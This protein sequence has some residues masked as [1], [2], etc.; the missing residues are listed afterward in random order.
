[1]RR[2]A[3]EAAARQHLTDELGSPTTPDER[4]RFDQEVSRLVAEWTKGWEG[5]GLPGSGTSVLRR[6]WRRPRRS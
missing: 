2:E 3:A 4:A 6:L 5:G 1:M